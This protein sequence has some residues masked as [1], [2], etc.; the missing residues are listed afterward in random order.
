MLRF[1]LKFVFSTTYSV[2][3]KWSYNFHSNCQKILRT[4]ISCSISFV[5]F[6]NTRKDW[7]IY[8]SI[9][10]TDFL[11]KKIAFSTTSWLLKKLPHNMHHN[12]NC[13]NILWSLTKC[14]S[15]SA[16]VGNMRIHG[17]KHFFFGTRAFILKNLVLDFLGR[18]ELMM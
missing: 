14:Y 7:P 6:G 16:I 3:K 11:F 2:L 5:K 4:L 10:R 9:G 1:F 15:M 17:P 12:H 18:K 8:I 13:Q